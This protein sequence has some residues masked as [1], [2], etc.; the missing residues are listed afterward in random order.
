MRE[1]VL[2]WKL[3]R[4]GPETVIA[5][6]VGWRAVH[7]SQQG[8]DLCVW[9]I[10]PALPTE[11]VRVRFTV[12]GTGSLT[13]EGGTYVGSTLDEPYVWHLFATEMS[14]PSASINT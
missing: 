2:K 14:D 8:S 4:H 9:V 6:P 3:N 12:V 10:C 7:F 1:T 11:R 13:P 5:L